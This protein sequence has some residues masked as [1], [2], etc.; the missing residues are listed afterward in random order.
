[1]KKKLEELNRKIRHSRKKNIG[2]IHKRNSLRKAIEEMWRGNEK[3]VIERPF[4]FKE[5][6]QAFGRAYRSY[7]V[8]GRPKMDP[9]SFFKEIRRGLMEKIKQELVNRRSARIQTNAWITFAKDNERIELV[10]NSRMMDLH[11]GSDLDQLVDEMFAHMM[12]QIENPALSNSR[13][14]FDEILFLDVNF[15]LLNL[16][17]GSSYLPLPEWLVNK[18]AI[19]NPKK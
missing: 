17:R 6:E 3:P 1:M 5:R 19:I 10:Y 16:M 18:K 12:T 7:R 4:I 11:R 9:E 13:F 8:E 14:I 2:L 15:H